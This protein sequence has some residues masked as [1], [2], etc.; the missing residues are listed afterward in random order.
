MADVTT[1]YSFPYQEAADPPDGAGL[2]QD[3]AEAVET[4]LG[5]V[6]DDLEAADVALDGRL[7]IVE[8]ALT[9]SRSAFDTSGIRPLTSS[10]NADTAVVTLSNFAFKAGYAYLIE[11]WLRGQITAGTGPNFVV[12]PKL[13]RASAAGTVIHDPGDIAFTGTNFMTSGVQSVIMKCSSD[14]TQ[15]LVV[16]AAIGTT[17]TPTALDVEASTTAASR[18]TVRIIGTAANHSGAL[19]VPTS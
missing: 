19:E 3:L 11:F 2:G 4:A 9:S 12:H 7:D 13:K 15:T 16:T 10:T 8:L 6:E 18:V 14:T 17:G 1:R 5:D